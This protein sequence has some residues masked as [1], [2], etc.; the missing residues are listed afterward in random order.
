MG[1]RGGVGGHLEK[2]KCREALDRS[3]EEAEGTV[4]TRRGSGGNPLT[5]RNGK[6]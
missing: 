4:V 5:N 2:R 6:Q 1:R 3:L